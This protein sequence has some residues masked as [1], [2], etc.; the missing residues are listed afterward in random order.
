MALD[1]SIAGIEAK[2]GEHTYVKALS[3][4]EE[5]FELKQERE[6]AVRIMAELEKLSTALNAQAAFISGEI[7]RKVQTLL[8]TFQE[9]INGIYREIQGVGAAPLSLE[10]PSEEDTN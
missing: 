10:L 5:L 3:K 9:P 8:N 7:R 1:A 2:Q 4:L 6:L